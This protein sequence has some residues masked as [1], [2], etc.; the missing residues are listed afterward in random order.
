VACRRKIAGRRE[1]W[2]VVEIPEQASADRVEERERRGAAAG[3]RLA[4]RA[5]QLGYASE[6]VLSQLAPKDNEVPTVVRTSD[7]VLLRSVMA[8]SLFLSS[9]GGRLRLSRVPREG[10]ACQW[11]IVKSQVPFMPLWARQPRP[12]P[13]IALEES[14]GGGGGGSGGGGSALQGRHELETA[15]VE[16]LLFAMQGI[17]SELVQRSSGAQ[18][19][20]QHGV[21]HVVHELARDKSLANLSERFLPLCSHVLAAEAF[22]ARRGRPEFGR[23]SHALAAAMRALLREYGVLLAQLETQKLQGRLSIQKLWFY[24]QPSMRSLEVL[25]SVARGVGPATGGAL[26][27]ELHRLAQSG[28]GDPRARA[29]FQFLA[30][31]ATVPYLEMLQRWVFLGEISDPYKEFMVCVDEDTSKRTLRED[32]NARYWDRRYTLRGVAPEAAD[33]PKRS[34]APSSSAVAAQAAAAA[35]SSSASSPDVP[36]FLERIADKILTTGKYLN[37]VRE[38]GH[39]GRAGTPG[40]FP[41]TPGARPGGDGDGDGDG[42]DTDAAAQA[43]DELAG[44]ANVDDGRPRRIPYSEES[45]AYDVIVSRAHDVASRTLLRLLLGEWQLVA[46]L[47]SLKHYFLLDQGDFFV[48]FMDIAHDEL[49]KPAEQ[50]AVSRL[51]SLLEVCLR[52]RNNNDPFQEDLVC[53]LVPYAL[54]QHVEAIHDGAGSLSGRAEAPPPLTPHRHQEQQQ[55]QQQPL[56]LPPPLQ[57][58][59]LQL[60]LAMR[61]AG[62]HGVDAFTLD[63]RVQWPLSLVLSR[64]A[65]TKYQLIF[66]HLF[67]CKHVER[68]LCTTWLAHQTTK[69]LNLRSALGPDYCLRQRMLHFLQNFE[70]YIMFEVLEP[71]WHELEQRLRSVKTVDELMKHHSEFLDTSMRE[72]LLTH[73]GLLKTLAKIMTTCLLFAEQIGRF[74]DQLAVDEASMEIALRKQRSADASNASEN[75]DAHNPARPKPARVGAGSQTAQLAQQ[76]NDRQKLRN[77]RIKVQEQHVR[78]IVTQD[79]YRA[80]IRRSQTTFD[81]MLDQFMD[82]LLRE[83]THGEYHSH[84]SNLCTRLDFNGYHLARKRDSAQQQQQQAQQA[85][86]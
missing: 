83:A 70:Y 85:E 3:A 64:E 51:Q 26:L 19:Q 60:P 10:Q 61:F 2:T 58:Q 34:S 20:S 23:V 86:E 49:Q 73:Q 47:R 25:A 53:D 56:P 1:H 66:R 63:F 24:V 45:H 75:T 33:L 16:A 44:E 55:H 48:H 84:L 40:A 72:C 74:A 12:A 18:G 38:C 81:T 30:Q 36:F 76:V 6:R 80:M 21:W 79:S 31:A 4:A 17:E 13:Q 59:L 5:R 35:S 54:T 50:I 37:V 27:N 82:E 14:G 7:C 67:F 11:N 78:A 41:S 68:Q 57:L 52:G 62:L 69:A 65:L 29:V 43:M 28:G 22:V 42:D 39:R 77:S 71:R 46:R 15:L 32:F 9:I 8:D